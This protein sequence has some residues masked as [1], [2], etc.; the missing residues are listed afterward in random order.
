MFQGHLARYLAFHYGL[1]VIAVEA[2]GC[3]LTTAAKYDRYTEIHVSTY[4]ES[5]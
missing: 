2:V 3:H 1:N 5:N 4:K